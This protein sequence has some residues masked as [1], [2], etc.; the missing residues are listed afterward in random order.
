LIIGLNNGDPTNHE[1]EKGSQHRV[2][3]GLAQVIV[4][5]GLGGQGK[6]TLR[7]TSDGLAAGEIVIDVTPGTRP[8][9][10]VIPNPPLVVLNWI[11]SP[12]SAERPNPDRITGSTD[13]NS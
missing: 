1:P 10:P 7:A 4:Q 2:F 6:L 11:R 5:S 12:V 13:M 9:V 3:H 8:A